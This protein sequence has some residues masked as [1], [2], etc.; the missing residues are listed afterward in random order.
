[1]ATEA[2]V[3]QLTET[4]AVEHTQELAGPEMA[5]GLLGE[6]VIIL[7]QLRGLVV[8]EGVLLELVQTQLAMGLEAQ[9][10]GQAVRLKKGRHLHL[11]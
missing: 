4:V 1:M 5:L 10:E 7:V 6:T 2:L 8:E 9:L 11:H 3:R